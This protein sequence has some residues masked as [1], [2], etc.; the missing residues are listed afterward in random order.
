LTKKNRSQKICSHKEKRGQK[1][2]GVP[3]A[4]VIFCCS[5]KQDKATGNVYFLKVR[6][7]TNWLIF[8]KELSSGIEIRCFAGFFGEDSI[9][10]G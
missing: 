10:F 5:L 3:F 1:L 6:S 7:E 9:L 4:A 2:K 8:E